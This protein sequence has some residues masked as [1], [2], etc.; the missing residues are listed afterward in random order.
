MKMEKEIRWKKDGRASHPVWLGKLIML[1]FIAFFHIQAVSSAAEWPTKAITINCVTPAGGLVDVAVR[2]FVPE[3]SKILGVPVIVVNMPGGGGGICAQNTYA[4]PNDGYTWQAMG[5][6]IRVMTVLGYHDKP[7]KDWYCLPIVGYTAAIA[8]RAD[9]P[10][11]TF[12]DLIEAMK[13]NPDKILLS[14]SYPSTSWG[15]GYELMKKVTGLGGRYVTY[16]GD[17]PTHVALLSGDLQF[18]MTGLGGQVELLKGGKIRAL[19][20]FHDKPI[21][22]QGYGDIP[23][24]TDFLPAMK[25]YLP[26]PAWASVSLRADTPKPILKKIDDALLKAADSKSVKE[27]AER[28]YSFPMKVVGE[29]AQKVF[30]RQAS[31]ECWIL[32]ESGAAK[33]SPAEFGI[34]KP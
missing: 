2:A 22:I 5:G 14:G 32:F 10:Y 34:P 33:K 16:P 30:H 31:Q 28:N 4:A 23:A 25:P 17:P 29:E 12:P 1:S 8:V 15:M 18:V 7:P 27:Y 3:I 21:H 9:S 20:H 6:Q 24:I 26:F 13:K 19:A 11:K